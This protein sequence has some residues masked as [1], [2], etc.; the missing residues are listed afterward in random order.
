MTTDPTKPTDT[1]TGEGSADPTTPTRKGLP[2]EDELRALGF[3][4]LKPSGKGYGLPLQGTVP[5]RDDTD[6]ESTDPAATAPMP[7]GL[8]TLAELAAR[9]WRI[10]PPSGKGYGLPV[11]PVG[12]PAPRRE[13]GTDTENESGG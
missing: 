7:K 4:V 8:P 6:T 5:K 3:R 2:T 13:T 10:V 12:V 9:G 11:G 1:S